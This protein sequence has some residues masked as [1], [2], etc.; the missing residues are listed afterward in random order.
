ME[1]ENEPLVEFLVKMQAKVPL[2][3]RK[4]ICESF[5]GMSQNMILGS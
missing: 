3:I 1:I 5:C 2:G 4:Q